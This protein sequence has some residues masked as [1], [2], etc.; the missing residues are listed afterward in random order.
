MIKDNSLRNLNIFND[1][2]SINE[3]TFPLEYKCYSLGYYS[4]I[5]IKRFK[6]SKLR[7][8]YNLSALRIKQ[9]VWKQLRKIEKEE[10]IFC[11]Y[12]S[13]YLS[14]ILNHTP[15]VIKD[16]KKYFFNKKTGGVYE[17]VSNEKTIRGDLCQKK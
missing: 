11:L 15:Y 10:D 8:K 1:F 17:K 12:E 14:S 2:C 6:S 9:I 7:K 3:I 4:C 13:P 5:H 16:V